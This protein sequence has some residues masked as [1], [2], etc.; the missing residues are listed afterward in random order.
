MLV[1][2]SSQGLPAPVADFLL[3]DSAARQQTRSVFPGTVANDFQKK[4]RLYNEYLEQ[5]KRQQQRGW[6]VNKGWLGKPV[7]GRPATFQV[8]VS[9]AD[10]TPLQFAQVSGIFQRP[11]DSRPDYSFTMQEI[12]PGL[13]RVILALPEPGIYSKSWRTVT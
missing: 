13:Y 1:V 8:Q 2:I 5:A 12:E 7:T 3:P 6:Q 10:G 9:E 11:S 4:E